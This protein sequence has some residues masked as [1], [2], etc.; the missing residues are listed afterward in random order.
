MSLKRIA[1]WFW[2]MTVILAILLT[3]TGW[4][5][6]DAGWYDSWYSRSDLADRLDVREKTPEQAMKLMLDYITG[7]SDTMD[8]SLPGI[9]EVYNAREKAHM[10]DVRRL[11]QSAMAVRNAAWL[12]TL[13]GV[14]L[15]AWK[16]DWKALALGYLQA[17]LCWLILI[18]FLGLWAATGFTDFW[19]HFH[20][21]FFDN[22]L[23]LLNPATDFMIRICPEQLFFD[24]V[25][26]I[27]L[28][29]TAVAAAGGIVSWC[30]LRR[31]R[32]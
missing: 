10:K 32:R 12:V 29:I 23:W 17:G 6:T 8:G 18:A 16:Q 9:G 28:E 4:Q 20:E 21:L 7:A 26:R 27:V 11:Y 1:A 3:M 24:L 2:G 14:L 30:V 31:C 15:A 19:T 22:D 5:A 25:I 13:A